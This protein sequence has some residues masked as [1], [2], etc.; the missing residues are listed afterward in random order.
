[1]RTLFILALLFTCNILSAQILTQNANKMSPKEG[2]TNVKTI[3]LHSDENTSVF[4]IFVKQAVRK[5]V[6]QYHT[7]VITILD[8]T[9]RM[10]LGGDYFDVKKGDHIV[11]PPNTAHA[12]I[13]TSSKPLKVI[14]VQSPQFLGQDLIVIE[15]TPAEIEAAIEEAAGSQGDKKKKPKKKKDNDIPEFEGAYD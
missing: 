11:I 1:M 4:M 2:Y 15:E 13:T 9:G 7:E 5:H 14:S 6:H 10:Y 8:G 12:V 3:P